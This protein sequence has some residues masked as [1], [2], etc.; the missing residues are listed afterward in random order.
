MV[1]TVKQPLISCDFS[2]NEDTGSDSQNISNNFGDNSVLIPENLVV[3][4]SDYTLTESQKSVLRKGLSFCPTPRE[5]DMG[6]IASDLDKFFRILKLK[7]FF[8]DKNMENQAQTSTHQE[9][10]AGTSNAS[11]PIQPNQPSCTFKIPST[12]TPTEADLA[13]PN[14]EAFCRS[15]KFD[16]SKFHPRIPKCDNLTLDE[17]KGLKELQANQDI[18]IKKEDKGSAIVIQNTKDYIAEAQ[19]QLSDRDHYVKTE[20][21]LTSLH[22]SQVQSTLAELLENN[23]INKKMHDYLYIKEPRVPAFYLLPKIHKGIVPPPGRPILSANECPTER[24]SAFV[25]HFLKPLVQNIPSYLKDTTDFINKIESLAPLPENSILVTLDVQSLY[26]NIP[27]PEG[28]RSA[29]RALV[30]NREPT[31]KPSTPNLVKLLSLVLNC[32]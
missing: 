26:T 15:V 8:H 10:E 11:Q 27:I 30:H 22:N 32:K 16:V 23:C 2:N 19:K 21:N 9:P 6:E 20:V 1:S 24:I 18:V 28:L 4:L 5:P 3:N 17:R 31:D 14:L 13:D 29:A 25:D 12:F 7:S